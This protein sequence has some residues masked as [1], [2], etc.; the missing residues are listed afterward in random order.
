VTATRNELE[1]R[2]LAAVSAAES[3]TG[4]VSAADR[5]AHLAL[6]KRWYYRPAARR[7]GEIFFCNEDGSWPVQRV[8]RGVS[9]VFV[10]DRDL[11]PATASV[12]HPMPQRH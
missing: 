2:L 6:L 1:A 9:R 5:A 7:I 8:L 12:W 3:R 10:T 4:R 11:V